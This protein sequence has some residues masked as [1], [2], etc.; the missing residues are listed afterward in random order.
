MKIWMSIHKKSHYVLH[1]LT[2]VI[3][4]LVLALLL[5]AGTAA[6][7]LFGGS[8]KEV[9][10]LLLCIT[11]TAAVIWLATRLGHH[12]QKEA[13][14]FCRDQRDRLYFMDARQY[15]PH[16]KG[17]LGFIQKIWKIQKKLNAMKYQLE[18]EHAVPAEA[19]EILKVEAFTEHWDYYA[20]VCLVRYP[21][22]HSGKLTCILAKGYEQEEELLHHLQRK[23]SWENTIEPKE[24]PYLLVGILGF[25]VFLICT[26]LCFLSHPYFGYLPQTIYFPYLGIAF[27]AFCVL[28]YCILKH[29]RGE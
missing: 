19:T 8:G 17:I 9:L 18:T 6:L 13:T 3:A 16:Q 20:L 4:L 21:N 26:L 12:L 11:G 27:L 5:A 29:R 10:S 25:S 2:G 14:I 7:L 1:A 22:Q 28:L 24:K 23:R 15:V